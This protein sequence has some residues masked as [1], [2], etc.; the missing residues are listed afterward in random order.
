MGRV[1]HIG[2][3]QKV[4]LKIKYDFVVKF[5]NLDLNTYLPKLDL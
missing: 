1:N 2:S 5:L 3:T 4:K